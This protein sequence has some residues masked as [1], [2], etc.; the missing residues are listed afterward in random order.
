MAG[1]ESSMSEGGMDSFNITSNFP[2]IPC[3]NNNLVADTCESVPRQLVFDLDLPNIKKEILVKCNECQQRGLTQSYKWLAEILYALKTV[4]SIPSKDQEANN[5][6]SMESS[7]TMAS[8]NQGSFPS[9]DEEIE[10]Y[11][12]AKGYFDLKEY[13]RCTFFTSQ[14]MS[15]SKNAS[16][17][18]DNEKKT[19]K[20]EFLH[21]YSRYLS[22]EKKRLDNMTDTIT[23]VDAQQLTYLQELRSELQK[24][25]ENNILDGYCTYLYGIVLKR[26]ELNEKAKNVLIKAVNMEP[27]L[28]GA[29][30][31]LAYHISDR[32]C[33]HSLDL[34]DHWIKNVFL[35]HTYLELQ[36]NEKA[37]EIYFALQDAGLQEST[38]LLAQV[39][40]AYHN[41][42][43]VDKAVEYF[44]QLEKLD[45]YRLDNL[46]TY[47]NLLYVKEQRVELAH[48]AHKTVEIDKYRTETCCVIGNYYS[49]RSQH[50]KAVV[51]FQ[52]A[53]KLN[54]N[55]LS[56]W[57]LMGHEFMELKNTNA[58]IQSYRHAIDV[59]K[60]DYRAWYGLGQTYELLKMHYYCLYY[61][62]RAQE[63]RPNDSRMLVA[64]GE[65]Y[66][67]LE[68][69]S[70]AMKCYWKAHCVGDIEGGIALFQLARMY[71][72]TGDHEQAANAYNQYIID[73]EDA[74]IT[75]RDQQSKA[76]KYLANYYVKQN[77]LDYAYHYAQKCT[78][79]ADTREEGKSLL[80]EVAARRGVTSSNSNVLGNALQEQDL[81]PGAVCVKLDT[82]NNLD[83]CNAS[84]VT[85]VQN[86]CSSLESNNQ[87]SEGMLM[88]NQPPGLFFQQ[89]S[90]SSGLG[91][92]EVIAT[93]VLRQHPGIE[94]ARQNEPH[95]SSYSPTFNEGEDQS[96][97]DNSENP[98]RRGLEPM[99]LTFTP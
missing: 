60:R 29:W 17:E 62:K 3:K 33:L 58:A 7:E 86:P 93:P 45:P 50:A 32:S 97:E 83:S 11:L 81:R 56:A 61:Y 40:I 30:L 70:D 76:Y 75:E 21:F 46:D 67:K 72:R 6:Y 9:A 16:N 44:Q 54:P 36:L 22:G 80:K 59:N 63:L 49:L 98:P 27:C 34:P 39:A 5:S 78:E 26:L 12:M 87:E 13:D 23:S 90:S 79:F 47:S 94:R 92:R 51:Y 85:Q 28:W 82:E 24:L 74:G 31:E 64:L 96:E 37:L 66:E 95:S 19:G 15:N 55:Y 43:G 42:R 89:H 99:N 25:E 69:H 91:N 57:T 38:Y 77:L 14:T 52:R 18:E 65:C 4:K 2:P 53:L 8:T 84:S 88:Q 10:T 35:A 71:E 41:M 73:T 48:L 20:V 68:K 1:N